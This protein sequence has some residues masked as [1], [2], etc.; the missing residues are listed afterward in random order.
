MIDTRWTWHGTHIQENTDVWF[1]DGTKS[2]EEPSMGVDFLLIFF[3]ET[4]DD[5]NR[6]DPLFGSFDFQAG[7]DGD[8]LRE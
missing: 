6:D 3:F 1:E 4:K 7:I 2:V 8:L 5:L